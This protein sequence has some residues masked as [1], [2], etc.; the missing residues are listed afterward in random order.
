MRH[1]RACGAGVQILAAVFINGFL[2]WGLSAQWHVS[3][4]YAASLTKPFASAI[5]VSGWK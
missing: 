5:G 4:V 3:A 2:L 1:L